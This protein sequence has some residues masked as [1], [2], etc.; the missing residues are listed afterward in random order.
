[1]IITITI[2]M[3][4][5]SATDTDACRAIRI[6]VMTTTDRAKALM[7]LMTWLSPVFPVGGFSY[8]HGLEQAVH[9]RLIT[10]ASSLQDWLGQLVEIGSGWNDAVLFAESWRRASQGH[11]LAEVA[12]LAEA[13]AASA[14]R[15]RETMLQGAAFL[16]ATRA[17]PHEATA[18]LAPDCPYSVAVGAV[19]GAHGV[20]LDDAL[21]AFL[22]AFT[23]NLVQAAIRL[24][25]IGQSD[26]VAI[27][28]RF[29]PLLLATARRAAATGLDDLGTATFLSDIMAMRHETLYSRI[30][31][32]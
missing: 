18:K 8:S 16:Q 23:S 7:R 19:A 12:A 6:M 1:M 10:D 13:L 11:D 26:A 27:M 15:H 9:E 30:F 24:N 2:I 25:V 31:R 22:Q 14:E 17:W 4:T 29:E 32:S 3:G 28:S 21:G 20:A 5:A